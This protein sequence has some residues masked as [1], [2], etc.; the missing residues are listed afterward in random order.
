MR[1]SELKN[2]HVGQL[3][4][5]AVEN[6]IDGANRMGETPLIIAVVQH[7]PAA[8]RRLLEYGANPDKADH[9]AGL[10]AREYARRDTRNPQMLQLINSVKAKVSAKQGPHL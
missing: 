5:T 9:S 10:S 3:L 2:L 4:E 6:N 7:Q 1:L 8:M